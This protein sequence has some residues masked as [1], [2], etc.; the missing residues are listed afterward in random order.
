[1]RSYNI[2]EE[3]MTKISKEGITVVRLNL[4][5]QELTVE[6]SKRKIRKIK[7]GATCIL[8]D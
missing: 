6:S 2:T 7:E 3:E 5:E 4:A 1:M 8:T